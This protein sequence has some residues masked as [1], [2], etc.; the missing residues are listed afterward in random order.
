LGEQKNW[1]LIKQ[2]TSLH[3]AGRLR[4]CIGQRMQRAIY[5]ALKVDRTVCTAQVGKSIIPNL[6]KGNV[7]KVFCH[8]KG[9]Y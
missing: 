9:W 6:A 1:L 4:P 7:H 8:L 2:R 5:A 3:Q